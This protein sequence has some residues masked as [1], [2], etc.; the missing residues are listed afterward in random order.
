MKPGRNLRKIGC[1]LEIKLRWN[2]L[3]LSLD[4][5]VNSILFQRGIYPAETFIPVQQYGLTILMSKDDKIKEF[6]K[7]VLGQ[8]EGNLILDSCSNRFT[9]IKMSLLSFK[10]GWLK[11]KLRN[12]PW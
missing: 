5:G 8:A 10:N 12:S 1:E 9:C 2:H 3:F 7:N 4:Y 11:T 6:L